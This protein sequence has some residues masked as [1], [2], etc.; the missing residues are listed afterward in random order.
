M[1]GSRIDMGGDEGQFPKDPPVETGGDGPTGNDWADYYLAGLECIMGMDPNI[2]PNNPRETWEYEYVEWDPNGSYPEEYKYAGYQGILCTSTQ[3]HNPNFTLA[4]NRTSDGQ[5]VPHACFR[6]NYGDPGYISK[7]LGNKMWDYQYENYEPNVVRIS[8]AD[9]TK[10][11]HAAAYH[12]YKDSNTVATNWTN[13][14]RPK[15]LDELELIFDSN[16]SD[17]DTIAGD[18]CYNFMSH[19]WWVDESEPNYPAKSVQWKWS[20]SPIYK[21]PH[22]PND[23]NDWTNNQP[24]ADIYLNPHPPDDNNNRL[25]PTE[26][27]NKTAR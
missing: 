6:N 27:R 26:I 1:V 3:T 8:D 23:P 14:I 7:D 19:S 4:N 16:E 12:L 18:R 25:K 5:K 20:E 9:I 10:N 11:C 13:E 17:A 24:A 22:D 2:D 21:W 15:Y